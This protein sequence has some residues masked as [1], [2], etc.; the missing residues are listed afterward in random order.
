[1]EILSDE[2]YYLHSKWLLWSQQ[3][4]SSENYD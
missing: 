1:M 3:V 4:I 2:L